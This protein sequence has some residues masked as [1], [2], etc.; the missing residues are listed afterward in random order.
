MNPVPQHL[1]QREVAF[2]GKLRDIELNQI[3]EWV[4][5]KYEWNREKTLGAIALYQMFLFLLYLYPNKTI[6]P[7]LPEVDLIWHEHILNTPKYIEDSQMLFGRYIHHV[8]TYSLTPEAQK[9]T[10]TAWSE[11][12][13]LWRQHFGEDIFANA[14]SDNQSD[15]K[16]DKKN[17][18]DCI[19]PPDPR[20]S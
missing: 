6:V 1:T 12:L 18:G 4:S 10:E 16:S 2:W 20:M 5:Y 9:Q 8:P 15:K 7:P 11:T 13:D 19:H 14:N 17:K 3:L